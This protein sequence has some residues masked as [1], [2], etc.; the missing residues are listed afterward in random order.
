MW[1]VRLAVAPQLLH[2]RPMNPTSLAALLET[3]IAR[4]AALLN[5]PA[6]NCCRLFNS[7]ADGRDGLVIEQFGDVLIVQLLEG[8]LD[9][10]E[11]ELERGL[12]D[13]RRR[14]KAR[15]VYKKV[16]PKDRSAARARLDALHLDP[17]PWLG[18]AVE[19]EISVI[20]GGLRFLVRPYDGYST[21]LFLEHR[22]NRRRVRELA[23]AWPGRSSG[24]APPRVLNLFAY[25]CGFSVAAAA[26]NADPSHAR[27]QVVGEGDANATTSQPVFAAT[28][29]VDVAVKSLEWG[30][31]NFAANGLALEGQMFICSDVF[32]YFRRAQRQQRRFDVILLDPP[33]FSRTKKPP[34]V[35][36]LEDDLDRLLAGALT[37]LDPGGR[38]LF[39]TNHRKLSLR[40]LDNALRNTARAAG[41]RVVALDALPLPVDFAG[42][43][44]FSKTVLATIG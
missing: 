22:E 4:R 34:T 31:R 35:F 26:G 20:E 19:P 7:G 1:A 44:D 8:R 40:V 27:P 17:T 33:T 36:S 29:S 18:E 16:F 15:A 13:L 2:N 37:L 24:G 3:A 14:L 39:S 25:T 9:A 6:T 38:V 5:D 12:E 23:S 32:E 21:G 42:D 43:P 11:A 28:T 41:R 10:D 30:K